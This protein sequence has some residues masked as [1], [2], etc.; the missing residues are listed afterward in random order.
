MCIGVG[1]QGSKTFAA[2]MGLTKPQLHL[3]T[4][5]KV[6]L[7]HVKN[8]AIKSMKEAARIKAVNENEND[9]NTALSVS[10]DGTWQK[11]GHKSQNGL[12]SLMS[13]DTGK[14]LDI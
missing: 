9:V 8:V 4:I 10:I 3:N 1:L 14:V 2:I 5:Y 13:V 12:V 6:I 7:P 11:R